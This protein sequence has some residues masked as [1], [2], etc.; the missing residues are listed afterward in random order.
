MKKFKDGTHF[1]KH[2]L[3][4]SLKIREPI[5]IFIDDVSKTK[6]DYINTLL[7]YLNTKEILWAVNY[8]DNTWRILKGNYNIILHEETY[9]TN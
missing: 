2:V 6:K 4:D 3:I 9:C 8:Y 5:F 1:M 7:N